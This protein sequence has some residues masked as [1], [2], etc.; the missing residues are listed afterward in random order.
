[1]KNYRLA[2]ISFCHILRLIESA[3][4]TLPK[5]NI[6][7][8]S[9]ITVLLITFVVLIAG[10]AAYVR[11]LKRS[12]KK[13][14]RTLMK[15]QVSGRGSENAQFV[16]II[17]GIE[18]QPIIRDNTMKDEH[19]Y[20]SSKTDS[21]TVSRCVNGACGNC[22]EFT[23]H[24]SNP[25]KT[26]IN[27]YE[28]DSNIRKK[29]IKVKYSPNKIKC[30]VDVNLCEKN[31]NL[32]YLPHN[33]ETHFYENDGQEN[34]NLKFLPDTAEVHFYENDSFENMR[35]MSSTDKKETNFYENDGQENVKLNFFPDITKNICNK[36]IEFYNAQDN[37]E[38]N[39]YENDGQENDIPYSSPGKAEIHFYENDGDEHVL[40]SPATDTAEDAFYENVRAEN[41]SHSSS[42]DKTE[43]H[44]DET[45]VDEKLNSTCEN[46]LTPSSPDNTDI[47]C[48]ENYSEEN[49][50][51][52]Y[53]EIDFT[54]ADNDF[55]RSNIDLPQ[56]DEEYINLSLKQ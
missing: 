39:F 35:L 50:K 29:N 23:E 43:T 46:N 44:Y 19:V 34:V 13:R 56:N 7:E 28:T 55:H 1:M 20:V 25:D 48:A 45:K 47:H 30:H 5:E 8:C 33:I 22:V 4:Y 11:H 14:I 2:C 53:V 32:K 12:H 36:N 49:V 16:E 26:E 40:P 51:L 41:V 18:M 15:K 42:T 37:S 17:D 24:D 3:S 38:T 6:C 10:V 27:V 9:T 52:K 54:K 21:S 31:T